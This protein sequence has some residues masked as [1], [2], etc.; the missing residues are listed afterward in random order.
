MLISP[1][2]WRKFFKP[3]MASFIGQLKAINPQLKIAYHSDGAIY[4]II[5]DLIEIGLDV[6]NPVQPA[7]MDPARVKRE[8]GEHLCF[9]GSIDEQHTLPFGTPGEVAA[10]VLRVL[11]QDLLAHVAV[12]A[13]AAVGNAFAALTGKRLRHIPLTPDR[14]KQALA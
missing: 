9:W 12:V 4:P 14:V 8:F 13:A 6:L 1:G 2:M 5:P 11:H 3:R 7:C 10:E